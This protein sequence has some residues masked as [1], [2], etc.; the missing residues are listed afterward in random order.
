MLFHECSHTYATYIRYDGHSYLQTHHTILLT[1]IA[2]GLFVFSA[3]RAMVNHTISVYAASAG[4]KPPKLP[5]RSPL[6]WRRASGTAST[7]S[8]HPGCFPAQPF[9]R[10]WLSARSLWLWVAFGPKP[11]CRPDAFPSARSLHLPSRPIC[12]QYAYKDLP[13]SN[14]KGEAQM[15]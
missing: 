10:G 3:K 11:P 13:M 7:A 5:A 1:L 15:A 4:S 6:S 8:L 12:P 2:L 14:Q 9:G